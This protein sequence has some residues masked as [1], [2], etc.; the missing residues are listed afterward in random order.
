MWGV[1]GRAVCG[2]C[3]GGHGAHA[4]SVTLACTQQSCVPSRSVRKGALSGCGHEYYSRLSLLPVCQGRPSGERAASWC[5]PSPFLASPRTSGTTRMAASTGR[6]TSPNSR[7]GGAACCHSLPGYGLASSSQWLLVAHQC[8]LK[9]CTWVQVT[10]THLCIQSHEPHES[11]CRGLRAAC[12]LV[13]GLSAGS[14]GSGSWREVW[15]LRR[16]MLCSR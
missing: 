10:L 13:Q 3:W 8:Q 2:F 5:A 4:G 11:L 14:S 16:V 9:I 15:S 7:V 6:L 1:G 12:P